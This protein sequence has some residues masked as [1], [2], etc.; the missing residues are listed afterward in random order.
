[1]NPAGLYYAGTVRTP[2]ADNFTPA[3]PA[4][5]VYSWAT[6]WAQIQNFPAA[7]AG[8]VAIELP[9][10]CACEPSLTD[11]QLATLA[12]NEPGEWRAFLTR[13]ENPLAT[14]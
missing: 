14:L 3:L 1:M 4:A 8:C 7:F 2:W 9:A 6:A 10:P 11:E 12:K 13:R 5:F